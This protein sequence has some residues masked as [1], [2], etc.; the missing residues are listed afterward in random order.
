MPTLEASMSDAHTPL[1]DWHRSRNATFGSFGGFRMPLWYQSAKQEHLSVLTDA[2]VFDTSHMSAIRVQGPGALD[3]LEKCFSNHLGACLGPTRKPLA[4]GRCAYGVFLTPK[5]HVVDDAICFMLAGGDYMVVVNAGMGRLL[6]AHL[7]A[8]AEGIEA[9]VL[10]L[11]GAFGKLDV[12]GPRSAKILAAVID[13]AHRVFDRL[14]YF[15]FKGGFPG[16]LSDTMPVT[17]DGEVPILLSRTGYTGE[18]GFEI[19]TAAEDLQTVWERVTGVGVSLNACPCGLAARD[20]LRV[21][22]VLPLSHQDIGEWPFV[23]HPWP[24]ALPWTED[25]RSFTKP[26]VGARALLAAVDADYTY[27]IV[28]DDLR[29]VSLPAAVL[30]GSGNAAGD[31]LSCVTDMG[32]DRLGGKRISVASPDRPA[33]VV[34]KGLCCGFVRVREAMEEGSRIELKDK[35]RRIRATIVEDIRPDRTARRPMREML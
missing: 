9:K 30:D 33:G 10:S 34:P 25:G 22:A 17:I 8:H 5:G 19:F 21:G 11:D 2:G 6:C 24:F 31:V 7:E 20:S 12:Q 15:A 32:I 29:K 27:P 23:R 4:P 13:D 16:L 18:F 26:F 28:G 14:P 35:R 3:L 1:I